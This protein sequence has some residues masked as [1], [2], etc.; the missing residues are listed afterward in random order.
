MCELA[1]EQYTVA[2]EAPCP[3]V[4]SSAKGEK[5]GKDP[6]AAQMS[7]YLACLHSSARFA[8]VRTSFRDRGP[9]CE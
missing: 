2:V 6:V 5:I 9:G 3:P 4:I 1:H 7:S 8:L